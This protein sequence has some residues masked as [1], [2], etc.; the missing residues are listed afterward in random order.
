MYKT[1]RIRITSDQYDFLKQHRKSTGVPANL[2]VR[3][4]IDERI[5]KLQKKGFIKPQ[6]MPI[7]KENKK[8]YPADWAQIS[9]RIREQ[10]AQNKCE[11]CGAENHQPHPQTGS[12]VV[13]TVAH[14]NHTPED[15][16]EE[17]LKALC[18]LCHNKYDAPNRAKNRKINRNKI[19]LQNQLTFEF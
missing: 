18:Q 17:N 15:C 6:T 16:R 14:M 19:S 1:I 13:L 11:F 8:R 9:K 3:I 12:L 10:R 2:F 4:A 7:S 5:E